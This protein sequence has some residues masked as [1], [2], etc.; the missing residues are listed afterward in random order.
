MSSGSRAR[1]RRFVTAVAGAAG[2]LGF[3]VLA[4]ACGSSSGN[5]TTPA[6]GPQQAALAYAQCIRDNGVPDFPDPD[7]NGEF[8][9]VEHELQGDPTFQ[10]AQE[11][12][13]D[14]APGGEHENFGDP[15]F[16]AQMREFSQCMRENG[17]PDF[18]DPDPDG[19]LRGATH[20]LKGDPKF[21]TAMAACRG[22]LPGGGQHQ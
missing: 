4:A 8:S 6:A 20:E 2:L 22:K 10:A 3:L 13:R 21:A 15:A 11:A 1:R 9:G 14:L 18:P 19:R 5:E 17:L 16:V 7:A 12:C